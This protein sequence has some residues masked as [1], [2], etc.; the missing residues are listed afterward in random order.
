MTSATNFSWVYV[1][2][3]DIQQLYLMRSEA[4]M[5]E[6][7]VS[8]IL[9]LNGRLEACCRGILLTKNPKLA[10]NLSVAFL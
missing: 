3:R 8:H 9:Q 4:E 6:Q 2:T 7:R 5:M 1:I 10:H